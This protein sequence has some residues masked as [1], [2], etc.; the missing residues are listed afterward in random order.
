MCGWQAGLSASDAVL[1]LTALLE[2]GESD[3]SDPQSNRD[4]FWCGAD[5]VRRLHPLLPGGGGG[6][7]PGMAHP[8]ALSPVS[9]A[10]PIGAHFSR[11]PRSPARH[12][13]RSIDCD[14]LLRKA[15]LGG[16][17][18]VTLSWPPTRGIRYRVSGPCDR[19]KGCLRGPAGDPGK[20][21]AS[22]R[23]QRCGK[24]STRPAR[25]SMPSCSAGPPCPLRNLQSPAGGPG[26]LN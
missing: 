1:A 14:T 26:W 12:H 18:L 5:P 23:A 16:C 8:A 21:S 22:G 17:A 15:L 19:G 9:T 4:R 10:Q 6:G 7:E 11:F 24:A 13:N 3:A 2:G 20:P 25:C